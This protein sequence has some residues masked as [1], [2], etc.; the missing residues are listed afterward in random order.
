M[1]LANMLG[2]NVDA[3]MAGTVTTVIS[4]VGGETQTRRRLP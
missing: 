1:R 2:S 3:K 4:A